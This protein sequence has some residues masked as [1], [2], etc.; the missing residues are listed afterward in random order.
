MAVFHGECTDLFHGAARKL[1][2]GTAGHLFRAGCMHHDGS[3][4]FL[5]RAVWHYAKILVVRG[6]GS[7]QYF[8]FCKWISLLARDPAG[9]R[10][11]SRRIAEPASKMVRDNRMV[12]GICTEHGR[13]LPRLPKSAYAISVH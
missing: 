2:A 3:C 11:V 9:A 12:D 4:D 7:H 1:V 13:L 5:L 8:L 6:S 10:L